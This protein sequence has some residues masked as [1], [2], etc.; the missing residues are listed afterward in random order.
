[1]QSGF[2]MKKIVLF[3][4]LFSPFIQGYTLH[5][6]TEQAQEIG[7]KIWMNEGACKIEKLVW[8]NERE[9]FAS[10][11]I[12]HFIWY[13][14]DIPRQFQ[15]TFPTLCAYLKKKG[16][17][18]PAWLE[19][20]LVTGCPWKNREA[21]FKEQQHKI[22]SLRTLLANTINLQ[23]LFIV[24]RFSASMHTV[25]KKLPPLKQAHIKKQFHRIAQSPQGLYALIDY[26]N[27]KGEGYKTTEQYNG[28]GW[29]LLQVLSR[30][31][32]NT[33]GKPALE[34]FAQCAKEVL[35]IRVANAPKERNEL[36][37]LPG[38]F[39]RIDTYIKC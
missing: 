4:L 15:E 13:P 16:V 39:N 26:V 10:L 36:Q 19:K 22:D 32:G 17:E 12:G 7:N 28:Q 33:S 31:K 38:W 29:G 25:F 5:I 8:W 18:L 3:L 23:A 24:E 35:A 9:E 37:R 27:F 11:G 20:A 2:I 14:P 6:T 21:F 34:E 1:M 30:M